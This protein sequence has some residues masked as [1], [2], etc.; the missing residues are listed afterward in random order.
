MKNV[1][2]SDPV[3]SVMAAE[4]AAKFSSGHYAKIADCLSGDASMTAREIATR[5]AMSVEQVCRRLPEMQ[6][7]G[8]V[9]VV[10]HKDTDLVI[11][12][13]R[14]WKAIVK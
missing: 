14:A 10:Q 1:R 2:S 9:V 13:Y 11:D 8:M 12:G 4:R 7:A 5:C 3:T 6:R